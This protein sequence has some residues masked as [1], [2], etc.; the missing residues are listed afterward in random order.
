MEMNYLHK[1]QLTNNE[2]LSN[3]KEINGTIYMI[4]D[5]IPYTAQLGVREYNG[6]DPNRQATFL[7]LLLIT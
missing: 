6:V 2:Y 1:L 7:D 4:C 5:L 3:M